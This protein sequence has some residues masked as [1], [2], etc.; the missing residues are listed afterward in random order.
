MKYP[1]TLAVAKMIYEN[2][3]SEDPGGGVDPWDEL[4]D[5]QRA[6]FLMNARNLGHVFPNEYPKL[7]AE[8]A[9]YRDDLRAQD[10]DSRHPEHRFKYTLT[11]WGDSHAEI[12]TELLHQVNGGYELDSDHHRRGAFRVISGRTTS[13]LE[14]INP[15]Q[16]PENYARE[17][18]AWNEQRKATKRE[19]RGESS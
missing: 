9:Q 10:E 4:T 13:A 1:E 16:T 15:G 8:L 18:K 2:L 5:E 6:P 3:P 14:H 12:E 17:L 11:V 7:A 19:S